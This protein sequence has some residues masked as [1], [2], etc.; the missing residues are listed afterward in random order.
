MPKLIRKSNP[1]LFFPKMKCKVQI[2]FFYFK[3]SMRATQFFLSV[4][5]VIAFALELGNLL[6]LRVSLALKASGQTP[7]GGS[8][9][10]TASNDPVDEEQVFYV[11]V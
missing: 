2:V 1:I 4:C 5:E 9:V 11:I 10:F 7:S 6:E 8:K 3:N